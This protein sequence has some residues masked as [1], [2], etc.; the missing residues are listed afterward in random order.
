MDIFDYDGLK[1]IPTNTCLC[2]NGKAVMGSGL[3]KQAAIRDPE[4]ALIYGRLL[5]EKITKKRF[6]GLL[7][8]DDLVLFPTKHDWR[9]PS[10]LLI[11]ENSLISLVDTLS[12]KPKEPICFPRIGCGLSGLSWEDVKPLILSHIPWADFTHP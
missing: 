5:R 1:I 6:S 8:K 2:N 4:V 9:K 11:I 12:F 3:A 7:I 10:T